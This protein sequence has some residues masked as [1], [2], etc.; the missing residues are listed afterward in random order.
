MGITK[1]RS[2]EKHKKGE[3]KEK[4]KPTKRQRA[5]HNKKN[6][7]KQK[8]LKERI[9]TAPGEKRMQHPTCSAE[10]ARIIW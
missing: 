6:N 2:V 9:S 4:P 5:T 8:Q 1:K 7:P 10:Q 3:R